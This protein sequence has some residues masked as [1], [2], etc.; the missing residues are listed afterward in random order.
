MDFHFFTAPFVIS[1]L[2]DLV[3]I[4]RHLEPQ[5]QYFRGSFAHKHP[6]QE[7]LKIVDHGTDILIQ[8]DFQGDDFLMGIDMQLI[9]EG[10]IVY[11]IVFVKGLRYGI[12]YPVPAHVDLIGQ[13]DGGGDGIHGGSA[14]FLDF[15]KIFV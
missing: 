3:S 10:C 12:A 11:G 2:Y 7:D 6:V 5:P 1:S 9:G 13:D 14:G 8:F 15:C 4:G